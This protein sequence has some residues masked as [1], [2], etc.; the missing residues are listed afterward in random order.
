MSHGESHFKNRD[1]ILKL[2]CLSIEDRASISKIEAT[3]TVFYGYLQ[4]KMENNVFFAYF[5]NQRFHK[6][7]LK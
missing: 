5:T 7:G 3:Y 1:K 4:N 6:I 2:F